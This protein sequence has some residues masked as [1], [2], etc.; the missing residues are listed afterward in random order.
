MSLI[1]SDSI[2]TL[3]N[4][5][6][7]FDPCSFDIHP[8]CSQSTIF[9]SLIKSSFDLRQLYL[10][11]SPYLSNPTIISNF[12]LYLFNSTIISIYPSFPFSLFFLFLFVIILSQT[13]HLVDNLKNII[14]ST[15]PNILL[16]QI[17][18]FLIR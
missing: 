15:Y 12:L 9:T 4:S 16:T 10:Y 13:P 11:F 2:S 8:S 18:L 3:K 5:A 1:F 17:V 14:N 6:S 7:D